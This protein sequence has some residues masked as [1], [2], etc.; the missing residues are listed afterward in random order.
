MNTATAQIETEIQ[1]SAHILSTTI[2]TLHDVMD[3]SE[4]L[5]DHEAILRWSIDLHDW[6]K[7]LKVV[8]TDDLTL[9]DV[10]R[11]VNMKGFEAKEL[12][13]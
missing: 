13:H 9:S 7:V 1:V 4:I 12:N 11:L 6:E 5:D 10:R 2:N 3:V 8:S